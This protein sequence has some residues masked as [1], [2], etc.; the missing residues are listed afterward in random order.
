MYKKLDIL[1]I[2]WYNKPK[3]SKNHT[4]S[5]YI[6]KGNSYITIIFKYADFSFHD[7]ILLQLYKLHFVTSLA[8]Q[9][10]LPSVVNILFKL[11]VSS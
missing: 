4:Y 2:L 1:I 9:A 6:T 5:S 7:G 10:L 8:F 11:L 3:G